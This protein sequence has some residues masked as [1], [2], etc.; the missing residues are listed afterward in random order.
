MTKPCEIGLKCPFMVLCAHYIIT[1]PDDQEVECPILE[2][3]SPLET[4]LTE[5]VDNEEEEE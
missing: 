3:Q 5:Y 4:F 1:S 2:P